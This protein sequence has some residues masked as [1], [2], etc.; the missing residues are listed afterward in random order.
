MRPAK[1]QHY[2]GTGAN[3]RRLKFGGGGRR[4]RARSYGRALVRGAKVQH[5]CGSSAAALLPRERVGVTF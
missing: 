2:C 3:I 4:R 1:M 5:Y